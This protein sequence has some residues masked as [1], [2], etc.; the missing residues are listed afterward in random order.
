MIE[1]PYAL[2]CD[3]NAQPILGVLK[4][5]LKNSRSLLEIGAG[6]G[7][8]AVFMAPYFEQMNWTLVDRRENHKGISLWLKDFLRPSIKGPFEYE[9]PKDLLPESDF[10]VVFTCNTL[11][12]IPWDYCLKMFDDIRRVLLQKGLFIIYGA[13]NYKGQ[14]TSE[15]N[16]RF[17]DWLKKQNPESGIKNFENVVSELEVRDFKLMEDISMPANN[18][19]LVFHF[20]SRKNG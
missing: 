2:S 13:F 9:I 16:R 19:I 14:F 5:F 17:D 1:K 7:Q 6:T 11:H 20:G 4:S 12:M 18:R 10:D 15:S 3:K 8:H